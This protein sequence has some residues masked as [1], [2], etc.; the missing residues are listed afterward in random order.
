[1]KTPLNLDEA[2]QSQADREQAAQEAAAFDE[3]FRRFPQYKCQANEKL[4][5]EWHNGDPTSVQS[6]TECIEYFAD[7]LARVHAPTVAEINEER[8][9]MNVQELRELSRIENPAP[10]PD[11]LPQFY[12]TI[13]GKRVELTAETLRA[14]GSRTGELST[15]DLKALIRRFGASEVNKRLGVKPTLQP[16]E[17]RRV[18]IF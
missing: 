4:I 7:R 5:R 8:R 16:G 15:N 10:R 11:E 9:A 1:V 2:R 18:K 12:T 14:A 6:I 17:I 3:V 13:A